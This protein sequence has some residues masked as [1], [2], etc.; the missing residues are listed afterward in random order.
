[1]S[2]SFCHG[3]HFADRP[4]RLSLVVGHFKNK[5]HRLDVLKEYRFP[6][7]YANRLSVGADDNAYNFNNIC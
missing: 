6:C 2:Q 7:S 5:R 1:M 3:S 4:G